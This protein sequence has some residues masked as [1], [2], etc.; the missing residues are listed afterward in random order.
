MV[1]QELRQQVLEANL[2]LVE[3]GLVISTWGNVSGYDK[4]SGLVV[5]K[6]SGVGY[7]KMS[8]AHMTVVDMDGNVV[9]GDYAPS[10]D[11]VIHLELYKAFG[12]KGIGGV[13]HTHSQFATIWAQAGRAVPCYGTTHA[14]YYYGSVP[15]TR[16][17]TGAEINTDFEKNTGKIIV[18][19]MAG[20]DCLSTPATLVHSH[21]PFV[22]GATPGDAVLHSEVLE[23]IAEMALYSE[24]LTGGKIGPIQQELADKH[25]DRKFGENSYY[26][27]K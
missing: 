13:V 17:M 21:G 8:L 12:D 1:L 9:E 27:Q 15:V 10:V 23:Y 4:A 18:E 6:A 24:A 19:A 3:K 22:W 2:K 16:E 5:I 7:N 11:T 14:D 20:R 26:G 25:Y